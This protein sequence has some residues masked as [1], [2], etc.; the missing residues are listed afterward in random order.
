[1]SASVIRVDDVSKS[2]HIYDRPSDRLRQVLRPG[3]RYYHDFLALDR[4]SFE[5]G[6]GEAIGIIGRN[7]SG[8]STLLQIVCGVMQPT[9][10][11]VTV[12]GRIAALLELGSGF[13]PEFTGR[14]NVFLNGAVLG[15]PRREMERRFD[16]I[17]SFAD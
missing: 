10:G 6:R 8:K 11:N 12:N 4:V 5:V 13:N 3:R 1:M 9:S 17:A 16:E 2:Y 15:V 7:G 14:E